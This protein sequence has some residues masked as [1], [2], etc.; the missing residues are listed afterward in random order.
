MT[1]T[2]WLQ[3]SANS[4]VAA[5]WSG[6]YVGIG[7]VN[8]ALAAL[9]SSPMDSNSKK[10]LVAEVRFIRGYYYFN[11]VRFFGG[12]PIVTTVPDGPKAADAD[13]SLITRES[14]VNRIL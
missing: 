5:L 4:F 3:T 13:T 11:L 8:N 6:Y 14:V 7:R 10:I 2:I 9:A 1:W 12:V